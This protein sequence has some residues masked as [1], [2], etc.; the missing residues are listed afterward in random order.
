MI[1]TTFEEWKRCIIEDCKIELTQD[2][3]QQRLAVYQDKGNSETKK[4][5][6]LYGEQHLNNIINWY[7][8]ILWQ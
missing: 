8:Q 1:P 4:F 6:S 5:V 2:F 3:A 7:N